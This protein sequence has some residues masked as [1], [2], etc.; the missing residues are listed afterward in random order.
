LWNYLYNNFCFKLDS[1]FSFLGT[2]EWCNGGV[3]I[4]NREMHF[5]C[6][7]FIIFINKPFQVSLSHTHSNMSYILINMIPISR[8]VVLC[9]YHLLPFLCCKFWKKETNFSFCCFFWI[10][11]VNTNQLIWSVI[12]NHNYLHVNE[13][14]W[15]IE[16]CWWRARTKYSHLYYCHILVGSTPKTILVCIIW[17]VMMTVILVKI[18]L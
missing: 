12:S 2:T 7:K 10:C 6:L 1:H 4:I 8:V 16:A 13:I 9:F 17:S 18:A 15:F 3:V 11:N 5:W 14:G